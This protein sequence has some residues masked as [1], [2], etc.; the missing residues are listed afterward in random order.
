MSRDDGFDVADVATGHLD[1]PKVKALWRELAP[2]QDSMSR[3]L[4]LHFAT[5]LA[6]WRQG[7]RVAVSEAVPVWLDLDVELVSALGR[8]RLLDSAGKLPIRSWKSWFSP[9]WERR[10]VRRESGRL[11]GLRAKGK[12]P[13]TDA[14]AKLQQPDSGATPD[15]PSGRSV[16]HTDRPLRAPA[17]E[18]VQG[19]KGRGGPVPLAEIMPSALASL[20]PKP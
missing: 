20:G 9:A 14:I 5:L 7:C 8:A 11:G 4:M 13:L 6:S 10:E 12:R 16:R 1:D 2:D 18:T 15:R 19:T 3:A 17:R